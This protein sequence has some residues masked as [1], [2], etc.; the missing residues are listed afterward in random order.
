MKMER[1]RINLLK[2]GV[3][4]FGFFVLLS[5]VVFG[6][7]N[8]EELTAK[9]IVERSVEAHGGMEHWNKLKQLSFDK[10]TSLFN[11]DGS[12]ESKVEQFQ[13]FQF[14]P[15]LFGKIE[16][17]HN[18]SDLS[19]IF[20]DGKIEKYINDSLITNSKELQAAKNSFFAAQYV[21]CQ[22]FEL[23]NE[24]V[25]L[26]NSGIVI[27]DEKTVY[28]ID[29]SYPEDTATS[30]KWSYLIDTETFEII[31][32]KVELLDHTSWVEN[33]SFDTAS[34]FKFNAHRK[35]YRLNEKG[36]KT[37]LRAAYYYSNFSVK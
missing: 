35:S 10:T 31:A 6:C 32:N 34:G 5:V 24:G 11:D 33:L 17:E 12:L 8:K 3:I 23:L 18:G 4:S 20:E 21:V 7:Q 28:Q 29:V 36:E 26:E 37:Y 27:L 9:Q 16:W 14:H 13:L 1:K 2:T 22:P 30:N 15:N 25:Q 19:I